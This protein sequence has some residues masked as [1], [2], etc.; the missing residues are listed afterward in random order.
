VLPHF[1][2]VLASDEEHAGAALFLASADLQ[3]RGHPSLEGRVGQ[4]DP[5]A[6]AGELEREQLDERLGLGDAQI[7][8]QAFPPPGPDFF[9]RSTSA[10]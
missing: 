9:R 10:A 6:E 8:H 7:L 1:P 2:G 4:L 5:L 3:R